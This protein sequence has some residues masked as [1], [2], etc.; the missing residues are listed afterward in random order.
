MKQKYWGFILALWGLFFSVHSKHIVGGDITYRYLYS[1]GPNPVYEIRMTV[2]RD[3]LPGNT[4]FDQQVRI[5]VYEAPNRFVQNLLVNLGPSYAVPITSYNPCIPPPNSGL[6]YDVTTYIK[7][8]ELPASSSGYYLSWERCCRNHSISNLQNPDE[9]GITLTAFIPPTSIINNS[10][11][12]SGLPPTFLCLGDTFQFSMPATD[13]DGDELVYSLSVPYHGGSQ[14]VPAPQTSMAPPFIPVTWQTPFSLQNPFGGL[15]LS[16]NPTTGQL[17]AAPN[18][19]GQ[20]VFC[21]SVKEYRNGQFL[22]EVR[23]EMQVN[24]MSCPLNLGP[25]IQIANA[26]PSTSDTLRA[27][28]G[29]QNCYQIQIADPNFSDS[30]YTTISGSLLG[31]GTLPPPYPSITVNDG[32]TPRTIQFCWQP[33]CA[34]VA[35]TASLNVISR[36][37]YNCPGPNYSYKTFYFVVEPGKIDPPQLTCV[38]ILSNQLIQL[39]WKPPVI[40]EGFL[41]FEIERKLDSDTIWTTIASIN[42]SL[43]ST[44]L[45]VGVLN[46]NSLRYCYRMKAVRTGCAGGIQTSVY[47]NEACSSILTATYQNETTYQLT[48]TPYPSITQWNFQFLGTNTSSGFVNGNSYLFQSCTYTGAFSAY[49]IHSAQQC[50][51]QASVSQNYQIS[52]TPPDLGDLCTV[53]VLPGD[54]RILVQWQPST[55]D[56]IR[57]YQVW[58]STGLQGTFSIIDSTSQANIE[59]L[60]NPDQEQ[61]CYY[62]R[63]VDYCNE[64]AETEILCTHRIEG[65]SVPFVAYLSWVYGTWWSEG[66]SAVEI[67]TNTDATKTNYQLL[68][69]FDESTLSYIDSNLVLDKGLFCYK[70]R[71]LS[72]VGACGTDSWSNDTCVT[73]DPAI[74][75]PTAFTPNNDGLNDE[76]LPKG[77]FLEEVDLKIFDRWGKIVYESYAPN[78]GWNAKSNDGKDVP[79]GVY[80]Y[81]IKAKGFQSN[82]SM[83]RVGSIT[84]I[85]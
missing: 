56:D 27:V 25:L 33:R 22:S 58:R 68:A 76:F 5:S 7:S 11:T 12:F 41:R 62:I 61:Y 72:N 24:V 81:R 77:L 50:T 73:F 31:G 16:V 65:Y 45:D 37:N 42:D 13:A 67:Y 49:A 84:V 55:A 2:F 44:Y 64:S 18:Q 9:T 8:V 53:S 10:P 28:E 6:C 35:F 34:Q 29:Q 20:F 48:V 52:N 4:P 75:F 38:S 3:C 85:R 83:E 60:A 82:V 66:V 69:R 17:T 46:A 40:P 51:I 30:I 54:E 63:A 23:R 15:P 32:R 39:S 26:T 74:Y 43:A 78:Q 70:I 1:N 57:T 21:V 14:S 80:I 59:T 47:S 36:D 71:V 19:L 79:E